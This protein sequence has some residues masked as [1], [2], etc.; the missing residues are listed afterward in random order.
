VPVPPDCGPAA[1]WP[2]LNDVQVMTP[3]T[4]GRG[5]ARLRS[6]DEDRAARNDARALEGLLK[7]VLDDSYVLILSPQIPG[8]D[9]A[10]RGLLVGPGGVRALLVRRWN[11][12]FRQRGRM[13]E[14]NARGRLGWI[15][16]R[17]DPTRDGRLVLDQLSEWMR[18][19]L[20]TVLPLEATIAFPD[21]TSHVELTNDPEIE[22]VTRDNAPWWANSLAKARRMDER[23]AG[24]LLV[25]LGA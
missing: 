1:L 9:G 22:V 16:C 14:Y 20:G 3:S 19:A 18:D 11:G 21:R 17:T 7:P 5:L 12:H 4:G 8:V 13:W 15:P 24:R 10:L 23:S 2:I 25:A 6:S